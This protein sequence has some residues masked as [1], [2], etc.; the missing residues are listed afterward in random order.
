MEGGVGIQGSSL[1]QEP[2]P[3]IFHPP[4]DRVKIVDVVKGSTD[5]L[6]SISE[7]SCSNRFC[8]RVLS[9]GYTGCN[10][11]KMARGVGRVIPE[12][13]ILGY[14]SLGPGRKIEG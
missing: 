4:H 13:H 6:V 1:A 8:L 10:E 11:G 12:E 9:A 14:I 3:G 5:N 7:V 2:P